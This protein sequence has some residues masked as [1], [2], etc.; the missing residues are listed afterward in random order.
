MLEL[1]L[2]FRFINI[3]STLYKEWGLKRDYKKCR[4]IIETVALQHHSSAAFA[5]M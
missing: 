2:N 4:K 3:L 5:A 1:T